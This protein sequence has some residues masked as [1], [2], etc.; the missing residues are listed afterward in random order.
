[1]RRCFV[2]LLLL[3]L[4]CSGSTPREGADVSFT[5]PPAVEPTGSGHFA[6]VGGTVL[7][8]GAADVTIRDGKVEAVGVAAGGVE[9]VDVSGRFLAPAFIDAHV[10]LTYYPVAEQL[11]KRGVVAALDLAAPL[12]AFSTNVQPLTLLASGPMIT[13]VGGYPTQSWG[14]DGYG[15]P[16]ADAAEAEAAVDS[17]VKDGAALIK[18]PFTAD[19]TLGDDVVAALVA[20]AHQHGL[21]VAGHALAARDAERAAAAGVDVLAHTPVE[22]LSTSTVAAFSS[23]AVIS[24]LSAFGG[25]AATIG[26]LRALHEAGATVL[27]G[28]DL[29]NSRD[30]GI[31]LP[32]LQ[33]LGQAGLSGAEILAAGTTTPAAFFG[34]DELGAIAPG[35]RAALLVLSRDPLQ[36][37]TVL[38]EPEQVYVDGTPQL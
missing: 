17:L 7:G 13:A 22:E 33:L 28:T 5:D 15:L 32:E 18:T 36:D 30:A 35:K 11:L 3:P 37:P 1:M 14:R 6:L 10:H 4:A 21:K 2:L 34:L 9:R 8:W 26:N 38:A 19:P 23:R 25:S 31:Q 20:R 16:V 12:D 24:T 29:G 27:Y